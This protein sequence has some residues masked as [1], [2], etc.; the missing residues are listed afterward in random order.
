MLLIIIL[1]N[2]SQDPIKNSNLILYT[3]LV[4]LKNNN[5][6]Q[7][8]KVQ[9]RNFNSTEIQT[10]T[11]CKLPEVVTTTFGCF[12]FLFICNQGFI[13]VCFLN[14]V[15]YPV[16][17]ILYHSSMDTYTFLYHMISLVIFFSFFSTVIIFHS[18]P[19]I[20]RA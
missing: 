16:L 14:F 6:Q 8:Q 13:L 15:F 7:V 5:N 4:G 3:S 9:I 20:W 10:W 17:R 2:Y 11:S 19:N 18:V 1:T 12:S